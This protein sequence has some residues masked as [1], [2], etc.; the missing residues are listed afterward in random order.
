MSTYKLI[1][2][3]P[4]ALAEASRL[5][6]HYAG[7]SFEDV[8]LSHDEFPAKKACKFLH[9]IRRIGLSI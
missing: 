3:T 1:Y 2:F 5:V 9:F 7:Q 6:L 8:R 4:R